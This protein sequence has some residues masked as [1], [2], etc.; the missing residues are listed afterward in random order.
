MLQSA[1][2]IRYV[3]SSTG[4]SSGSTS[5]FLKC[6]LMIFFRRVFHFS[7]RLFFFL[8]QAADTRQEKQKKEAITT[9]YVMASFPYR[10][11]YKD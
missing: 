9:K 6:R 5:F 1:T 2:Y 10:V 8:R 3:S 7:R 4:Q 11:L